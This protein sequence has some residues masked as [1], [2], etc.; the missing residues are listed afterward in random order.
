MKYIAPKISRS[1]RGRIFNSR[2]TF[3]ALA[4]FALLTLAA[5]SA[6]MAPP[7]PGAIFSTDAGCTGVDLNIYASKDAVYLDGG[8]AHPGAA[9]LSDGYYY[10]QVTEPDGVLLGTSVGTGNETPVHVTNGDFDACYQLSAILITAADIP[11]CTAGSGY[12]TTEN[13]G[14]EYKVWVSTVAN[15][16][17]NSSKTDNFKVQE[18]P[19]PP[20]GTLNVIKFYDGN[21]NGVFDPTDAPITGWET[22]VGERS[23]F[24]SN[25]EVKDTPVSI[26]FF[27]PACYTAQEGEIA[28]PVHTWVHTNASIQ[29]KYVPV[30]GAAEIDFGNVCLGAGGGLTL[31]FWSNKNGSALIGTTTGNVS[32]CGAALPSSDL[33]WLASL[34]LRDGSGADFNPTAYAGFRTWL[35][36]ATATNMAYMLSAQLAAMELNV[37]NGKVNGSS[38]VYAPGTGTG[39]DFKTVCTLMGLAN[40]ELGLHGSVL[41]GNTNRAYQEALK[42]ALDRANNDQNFVQ[43][44]AA[45]CGVVNDTISNDLSFSYPASFTV[46]SC[47]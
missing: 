12:C 41:S 6:L 4:A 3:I 43:G 44:S 45:Q 28:D 39:G 24:D 16:D 47:P 15:F 8:P 19:F 30:P 42:N 46:P 31:G 33:V 36:N 38:I 5:T 2:I 22:H 34:N 23:T 40:T 14:G 13:P 21:A 18:N 7:L 17:P 25:F 32:V 29:S 9:G 20:Q 11:G 1:H 26:I 37:L 10:V 27:A 35:L